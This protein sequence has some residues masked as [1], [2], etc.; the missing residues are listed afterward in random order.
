MMQVHPA[1]EPSDVIWANLHRTRESR[2]VRG[3]IG[4]LMVV[5]IIGFFIVPVSLL[6]AVLSLDA[7]KKYS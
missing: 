3:A 6:Y 1:P 4:T 5:L 2:K 7:L